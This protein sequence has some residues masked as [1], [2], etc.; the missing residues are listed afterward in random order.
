M[1]RQIDEIESA[2]YIQ[3]VYYNTVTKINSKWIRDVTDQPNQKT[4]R[5]KQGENL[6]CLRF[7]KIFLNRHK[8][9]IYNNE[10]L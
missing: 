8:N 6:S 1:S 3:M 4:S 9:I 5:R 7:R 10:Y 2:E